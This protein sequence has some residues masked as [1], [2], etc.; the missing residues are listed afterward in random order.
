MGSEGKGHGRLSKNGNCQ[1]NTRPQ[2]EIFEVNNVHGHDEKEGG[3]FFRRA[4]DLCS[5]RPFFWLDT[6]AQCP[7]VLNYA[8]NTKSMPLGAMLQFLIA[9]L[10]T[11]T[12]RC[13]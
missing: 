4:C 12:S 2:L 1:R 11:S 8:S 5:L 6:Q 10:Y 13:V 9:P 3:R 7:P